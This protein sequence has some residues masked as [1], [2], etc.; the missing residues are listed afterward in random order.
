MTLLGAATVSAIGASASL[1]SANDLRASAGPN[2]TA[3]IDD[4]IHT[5]KAWATVGFAAAGVAAASG[6]AV[7]LWPTSAPPVDVS[8]AP[9]TAMVRLHGAF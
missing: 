5:K 8:G 7:L 4:K 3:D 6:L 9:G 1:L 2:T